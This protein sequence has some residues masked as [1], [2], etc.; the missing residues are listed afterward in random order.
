MTQD[1]RRQVTDELGCCEYDVNFASVFF[2]WGALS[3]PLA[4]QRMKVPTPAPTTQAPTSPY[5]VTKGRLA[6]VC[7]P[8]KCRVVWPCCAYAVHSVDLPL[9]IFNHFLDE[10]SSMNIFQGQ[11]LFSLQSTGLELVLMSSFFVFAFRSFF[12]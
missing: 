11:G 4:N 7:F 9:P 12:K 1:A 3:F 6:V 8:L 2:S 10:I 5:G